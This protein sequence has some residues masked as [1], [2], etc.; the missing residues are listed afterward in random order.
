VRRIAAIGLASILLI[1]GGVS[2]SNAQAATGDSAGGHARVA[3]HLA[4]VRQ[5]VLAAEGK[6]AQA[7]G[8]TR[9]L[10][11]VRR[12]RRW[13]SV[14]AAVP[15][16]KGGS[17]SVRWAVGRRATSFA[18]RANALGANGRRLIGDPTTLRLGMRGASAY[19]VPASTRVYSGGAVSSAKAG[20]DGKTVIELAPG[21]A[22][23]VVGG[24]AALA[25]SAGLP[26]GMFATVVG[27]SPAA[28]GWRVEA[29]R[30]PIDQVL[31]EV[32]VHFDEDVEPQIV[33]SLGRPVGSG[34]RTN[35]V[36]IAGPAS[37]ARASSLGSV[38]SC[39]HSGKST[40]AD[41][42]F[43]S[44]HPMPLS[45][46]LT[47]M[48]ALDDFDSGSLFPHR[49][50]FFLMQVSGEAQA[51]VG[52]EAKSAFTCE[53]SDS[54]RETHRIAVPLGAVGPVPVTMY[55]EP[56]LKFEVSASGN[57]TLS[58]HHY[59]GI[60]LEQNGFAPFKA[61][62]SHSADPVDFH[63]S[64]AIGASLFAG[65]DLSVMFGAGAGD[66]ALQAGI[67]GAF[68]PDFELKTSTGRPGCISATA[69]LEADL[70]VRLQVL[71]KRWSA[72]LA[73]LTSSPANLGGPWCVGGGSGASPGNGGS[74]GG[75]SG[76][77]SSGYPGTQFGPVTVYPL[78]SGYRLAN[79]IT[80]GREGNMWFAVEESGFDA[81]GGGAIGRV[82]T[83]GTVSSFPL[84]YPARPMEIA[85]GPEGNLWFTDPATLSLGEATPAGQISEIPLSGYSGTVP[86]GVSG[87]PD[88]NV[89]FTTGNGVAKRRPDGEITNYPFPG[90]W[91]GSTGLPITEGPE[92]SLWIAAC[93]RIAKVSTGGSISPISL[94]KDVEVYDIAASPDNYLWITA[95]TPNVP[96]PGGCWIARVST[97]GAQQWFEL[98][99]GD[100]GNS[101]TVG[102]EGDIWFVQVD[103][104]SVD[105]MDPTTGAI[106]KYPPPSG[107]GDYIGGI[108]VG[109]DGGIWTGTYTAVARIQP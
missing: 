13:A 33:D 101:L 60:T 71:V 72:Q 51:T 104:Q 39:E 11:Q 5:G 85:T 49:D 12:G 106:T 42:S 44:T 31:D 105:R 15:I 37:F 40:S 35:A 95:A 27:V 107:W 81:K 20:S 109:P 89:W 94:E 74:S 6:V 62:L 86:T 29:R 52:F 64:A 70:G 57:V 9:V 79:D 77:S 103:S 43:V 67:Y 14:R 28:G 84:P 55:L 88:G 50:P 22:K 2:S 82:A 58:Q 59:W 3:L 32:S 46:E 47:H 4:L 100:C 61:R 34:A 38:F 93:E 30:A 18:V 96:W 7:R 1:V 36:R 102:P 8:I 76:G 92:G 91:C 53:L 56:T 45:I 10:V 87:G 75:G 80:A 23:P 83:D 66:W 108:T 16:R 73:S 17:F 98:P 19:S 25:P 69:K 26:Y 21:S 48:H 41:G 99:S 65:G 24:H 68:G 54:F 90:G 97:G 78:P 63:A